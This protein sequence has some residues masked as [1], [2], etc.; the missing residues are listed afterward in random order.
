MYLRQP[1][2]VSNPLLIGEGGRYILAMEVIAITLFALLLMPFKIKD[3][4]IAK[5]K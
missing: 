1:P 4:F 3:K 2:D 5:Y